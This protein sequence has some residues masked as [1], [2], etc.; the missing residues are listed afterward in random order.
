MRAFFARAREYRDPESIPSMILSPRCKNAV[1]GV[2][3]WGC[4]LGMKKVQARQRQRAK[5]AKKKRQ[6]CRDRERIIGG[7][8]PRSGNQRGRHEWTVE[9]HWGRKF[10]EQEWHHRVGIISSQKQTRRWWGRGSCKGVVGVHRLKQG[11]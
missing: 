4:A 11:G 10:L 8:E 3:W 6:K 2:W 9:N 5:V 1:Q 7:R